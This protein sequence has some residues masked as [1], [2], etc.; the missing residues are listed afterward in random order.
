MASA[1]RWA[2]GLAPTASIAD[3]FC[4]AGTGGMGE[5]TEAACDP[6]S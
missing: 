5:L 3:I 2:G 4:E 6:D 1:E